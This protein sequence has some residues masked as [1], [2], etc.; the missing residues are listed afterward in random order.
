MKKHKH[1]NG[2]AISKTKQ[3]Y[4]WRVWQSGRSIAES[5]KDGYR[6]IHDMLAVL[7]SVARIIREFLEAK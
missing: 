7:P 2:L 1:P 5:G 4:R 3:G 6:N